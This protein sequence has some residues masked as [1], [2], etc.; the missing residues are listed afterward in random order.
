M[1]YFSGIEFS[2]KET[3]LSEIN[4]KEIS[5]EEAK[6]VFE[7]KNGLFIDS[8]SK[9][10]Y[11]KA[12]IDGAINIPADNYLEYSFDFLSAYPDK[13]IKIIVY[14]DGRNCDSS[15]II[16]EF[17]NDLGYEDVN[18]LIN[19]WSLWKEDNLPGFFTGN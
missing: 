6:S 10:F 1:Y 14:C 5:F 2:F 18:I 16:T 12:H 19:G 8:R 17:L 9:R 3:R 4:K 11:E 15:H 13:S 7:N